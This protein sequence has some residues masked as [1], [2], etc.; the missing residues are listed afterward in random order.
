MFINENLD[1]NGD[2]KIVWK[3]L[4]FGSY[5]H[6]CVPPIA[7]DH[8][9]YSTCTPKKWDPRMLGKDLRWWLVT[10]RWGCRIAATGR[11]ILPLN[12]PHLQPPGPRFLPGFRMWKLQDLQVHVGLRIQPVQEDQIWHH[13]KRSQRKGVVFPTEIRECG[14]C[15]VR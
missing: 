5:I 1:M 4:K 9:C 2:L 3:F 14:K 11:G 7:P 6:Q 15:G 13:L 12:K 8:I 10:V